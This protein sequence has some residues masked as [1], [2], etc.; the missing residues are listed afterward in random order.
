MIILF[1]KFS[2]GLRLFKGVRLLQTL[3]YFKNQP[4]LYDFFSLK[5]TKMGDEFLLLTHFDNFDF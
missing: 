4:N 2:R 1:A 5:N 3:E